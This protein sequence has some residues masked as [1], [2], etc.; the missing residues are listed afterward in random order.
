MQGKHQQFFWPVSDGEVSPAY[1]RAINSGSYG[2]VEHAEEAWKHGIIRASG[3]AG[4][5]P[6][7]LLIWLEF[8][9]A[10]ATQIIADF[11]MP[12]SVSGLVLT[13]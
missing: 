3:Q 5:T 9:R 4:E 2:T 1:K 10:I 12:F 6:G 8:V 13:Q 7:M 11:I